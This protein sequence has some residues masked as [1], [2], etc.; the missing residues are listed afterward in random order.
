MAKV[1]A[2]QLLKTNDQSRIKICAAGIGPLA[3]TEA[4]YAAR[5][6][7]REMFDRDLLSDHRPVLLTKELCKRADLI[8]VMDRFLMTT[9]GKTLPP[10]KTYL[11]KEFLGSTGDVVDPWPDGRDERTI[12]RYRKCAEE[13][14]SLLT[15]GMDR[16]LKGLEAS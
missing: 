6:V 12:N 5:Y 15:V 4:S 1:I 11:L 13:L 10:D 14:R 8:L 7:I 3:G 9:P 16:I 2:E